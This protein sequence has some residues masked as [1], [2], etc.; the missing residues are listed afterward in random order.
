[1]SV[2]IFF[3]LLSNAEWQWSWAWTQ[4]T[5][6]IDQT[7]EI[8]VKLKWEVIEFSSVGRRGAFKE[9]WKVVASCSNKNKNKKQ[10]NKIKLHKKK[11]VVYKKIFFLK[12]HRC[13]YSLQ[14]FV[15]TLGVLR[16]QR[17]FFLNDKKKNS[18]AGWRVL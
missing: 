12:Y 17:L 11:R 3:F 16:E 18:V 8:Q 9:R 5:E 4:F 13:V 6:L 2:Y 7:I 1:M 10:T 15:F 14:L